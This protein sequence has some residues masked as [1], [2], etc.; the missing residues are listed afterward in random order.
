MRRLGVMILLMLGI[1][2]MMGAGADPQ[3][4]SIELP[5]DNAMAEL[6]SGPGLDVVRA[7]C[8]ACHSL[9]YIVRQPRSDAKRWE[10]EVNKMV[11]TYGATISESD[12][13]VIVAYLAIAYGPPE[14]KEAKAKKPAKAPATAP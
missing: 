11:K 1:A 12:A 4:R 14:S 10:G 2:V 13:K 5:P 7:N 9:D 6:K 3:V 8:M